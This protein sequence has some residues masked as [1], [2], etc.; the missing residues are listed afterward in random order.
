[1]RFNGCKNTTQTH[2]DWSVNVRL[3]NTQDNLPGDS[4]S[5]EEVVDKA[6]IVDEGVHI[7]GAQHKQGRQ[8]L[9]RKTV[10]M[11]R[12]RKCDRLWFV[13]SLRVFL[14]I[15]RDGNQLV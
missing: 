13:C 2:L 9:G 14:S 7:T 5:V 3:F 1:M 10:R 8:A 15:T 11:V 12:D 6:H 4:D